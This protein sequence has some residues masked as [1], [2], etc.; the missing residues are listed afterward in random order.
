MPKREKGTT[1][2]QTWR[3]L[4]PGV[5]GEEE[6]RR[7]F[8]SDVLQGLFRVPKAIP[9]RYFYDED[10][11]RLFQKIMELPEYYLTD[12]ELEI[13]ETQKERIAGHIGDRAFNL[14]ELGAGDGTKTRV[15][16][17]HFCEQGMDFRFVPIDI[18]QPA[19]LQLVER[20]GGELPGMTT[21]GLVSEYFDGLTWL[22]GLKDRRNV[23]LFLGSNIGNFSAPEAR[24][25]LRSLW[26]SLNDD[27]LVLVGFDLKKDIEVLVRAY[28][29][30][31]GVTAD[32]NLN[33][34]RRINRELGGDF[35]LDRFEHYS[36]YN[37][38]SGAVESYLVS[39]ERQRV[40]IEALKTHFS[41]QAW[42]PIHTEVSKKYL[43]QD[44]S[45][46][47]GETGF[48]VVDEMCD[49]RRYFSDSLWRVRKP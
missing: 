37:V 11:N 12:C 16:L 39:R 32:F 35:T 34:L 26:N 46:M 2:K 21:E 4:E 1:V 10:G 33:L 15:L 9:S 27:D 23:V 6:G 8:A 29:D 25:F 22:S 18:C 5:S 24:V 13:L 49:L 31:G 38:L 17:R 28:N 40:G 14:I 19:L 3:I 43:P 41:F 44:I 20:C 7:R 45:S 42:E 47:A 36:T 48:E 30:P